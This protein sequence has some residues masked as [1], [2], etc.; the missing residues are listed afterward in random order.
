MRNISDLLSS[1]AHRAGGRFISTSV[2]STA[3]YGLRCSLLELG[4]CDRSAHVGR[5]RATASHLMQQHEII[6]T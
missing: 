5:R 2:L 1:A 3:S 6:T 4:T